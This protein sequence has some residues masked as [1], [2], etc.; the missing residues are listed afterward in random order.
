MS[1]ILK[2]II[3]FLITTTDLNRI[4]VFGLLFLI[5][6]TTLIWFFFENNK[7]I[8]AFLAFSPILILDF[9]YSFGSYTFKLPLIQYASD[10]LFLTLSLFDFAFSFGIFKIYG[11]EIFNSVS[12]TVVLTDIQ[13]ILVFLLTFADTIF[14]LFL[15]YYFFYYLINDSQYASAITIIL[16]S[17]VTFYLQP[18]KEWD[19]ATKT[20]SH[21]IYFIENA[22]TEQLLIVSVS[23]LISF[24][25]VWIILSILINIVIGTAKNTIRPDLEGTM[26][27][28][29]LSGVAFK[30]TVIYSVGVLLHPEF[31]FWV[32]IPLIVLWNLISNSMQDYSNGRRRERERTD[33]MERSMEMN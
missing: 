13:N 19:T 14:L 31:S 3:D 23:F 6:Y 7:S 12:G 9:F 18:L 17:V 22:T 21:S 5:L 29:N 25:A 26:W 28:I 33:R 11:M 24:I 10:K 30:F 32:M 27:K 4:L 16:V 1:D 2:T 8:A 20:M 15:L